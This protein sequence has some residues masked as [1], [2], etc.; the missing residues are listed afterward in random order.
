MFASMGAMLIVG[1][2]T[3]NAFASDGVIFGVAYLIVRVLHLVLY[4]IGSRGDPELRGAVLRIGPTAI[5][6]PIL[7]VVAGFLD[8]TPQLVIWTAALALDYLGGL[9]GGARGW[10]V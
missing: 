6:A 1:L 9:I 3:P 4:A 5:I 10:R 8:G 2:A 7:L